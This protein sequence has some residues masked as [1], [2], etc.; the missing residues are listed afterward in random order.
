MK[1]KSRKT[2][3]L[4]GKPIRDAKTSFK[5]RVTKRDVNKAKQA[6]SMSCAIAKGASR[7]ANIVSVRIGVKVALIEF[8]DHVERYEIQKGDTER[9]RAFDYAK[10]FQP[11][12]IELMPP[13]RRLGIHTV[14]HKKKPNPSGPSGLHVKRR[15]PLRHMWRT[16]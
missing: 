9:I 14:N 6:R 5:V 8:K 11:G 16:P 13:T 3:S 12:T 15:T 10:Y 1:Q 2:C 4:G 7:T